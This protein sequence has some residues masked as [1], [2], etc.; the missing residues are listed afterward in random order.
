MAKKKKLP[1][2]LLEKLVPVLLVASIALAFAVGILWQKVSD[3]E[4]GKTRLSGSAT[5]PTEQGQQPNQPSRGK[6]SEEQASKVPEVTD[7]DHV[8]GN[9]DAQVYLIEYS[10]YECPFCQRFHPTAKQIVDDYGGDVAWVYRHFPLEQL[11]PKARPAAMAAECVNE[12]GGNDAFWAFTDEVFANQQTALSDLEATAAKVGA[13]GSAFNACLE[14]EKYAGHVDDN[15][16]GGLSAGVT[17]TPGNIIL[18]QN[19]EAWLIPG[20]VP[21]EQM[22][23]TIDEALQG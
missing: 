9:R 22:K 21:L 7:E 19:G 6:L 16:E 5:S 3:M 12:I 17:G 1:D 8:R 14:S 15:Y 23:S 11:H 13:G 10:D 18:N 4:G 20:A 2:N